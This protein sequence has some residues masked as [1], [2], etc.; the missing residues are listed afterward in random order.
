[1]QC[2]AIGIDLGTTNSAI[3]H[4][5][6]EGRPAVIPNAEGKRITPSVVYFGCDPPL[7]GEQAKQMQ[8]SGEEEVASFFKRSMGDLQFRLYLG[9][10]ERDATK[11]SS[12][13][14]GKLKQDAG[15]ALGV[16][17][18]HA[19]ITVPAYFNNAQREA[20]I[21]AG[22]MAGLEVLQIINEPTS[23]ALAY[24]MHETGKPETLLVYDLGGGTFDVTLVRVAPDE[25]TVL[26]TDGDHN[27]GGKDWDDRIAAYL[28]QKFADVHGEN[29]LDD[30]TSFNDLLV[31]VEQAK[32]TLS[33]RTSTR[34][35]VDHAGK[36]ESFELPRETF[37]DLTRD[38]M[39]R[40][41]R[42]AQQVLEEK[43]A[44]WE[45]LGG[46]V[47][48]GG[49]TRMPMVHEYATRMSGK[50]PL[51]G[52]N[53]DE[54]VAMGAAVMAAKKLDERSELQGPK[55]FLGA[56]RKTRDVMS[57]SLG[58][59]AVSQDSE[60]Y[61]NSIILPKNHPIPSQV[62]RP[63]TLQTRGSDED[64]LEVYMT[65]GETEDPMTC[66]FLGKYRF[67]DIHGSKGGS[68]VLDITYAYDENGVVQ[69]SAVE[70][71]S[72]RSLSMTVEPIPQDMSWLHESPKKHVAA[73]HLTA[74]LAFDVSG[75]MSGAPLAQAKDA[76]RAF[77]EKMDLA[78]SSVGI[79]SFAD[80]NLTNIKA[81]QNAK[82]IRRAIGDLQV[83][84]GYG[85]AATPFAHI[86]QLLKGVEGLRFIV[87][88]TD[89]VWS[90]Q[91]QAIQEAK[92]CSADNIQIIAIGFGYADEAF[93][94][95]IATSEEGSLFTQVDQ[96]VD[97]F[98]TIAQELTE[99]AADP[100]ARKRGL[101]LK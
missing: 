27:L 47:L 41:E 33:A 17:I 39:E 67:A 52:V 85:N 72:R 83:G 46:V 31:R 9:G 37:E 69:V 26:A 8:A 79:I 93:L 13:V 44:R 71:S 81:C 54:V 65:Q 61:I 50:K 1:M 62:S 43:E 92:A 99:V 70:Q 12:L 60:R 90:C 29:P 15:A 56:S 74:Y 20:T 7:V 77:V 38:L 73:G 21:E 11:L 49:S 55:H 66:S 89:G 63:Y 78:H 101:R 16:P 3:A 88:L 48:V 36:R 51:A 22:R 82:E 25:L 30:D 6:A 23:A 87:A 94:K 80:R 28:G 45:D 58:M 98:G 97:T 10:E 75:S 100:A 53:V 14:L 76:A 32:K 35:T 95:Q 42:L 84:L 34:V 24:R 2:P 59:I 40:T 4:I 91:G 19:V 18:T 68:T 86:H 64:E 57:H 5:D 96:L